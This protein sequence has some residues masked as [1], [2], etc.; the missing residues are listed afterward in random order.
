MLNASIRVVLRLRLPMNNGNADSFPEGRLHRQIL[1]SC[2][3][4]MFS[5]WLD[6]ISMPAMLPVF[7]TLWPEA[8]PPELAW[9]L[10]TDSIAFAVWLVPM[11]W[12]SDRLGSLQLLSGGLV[13]YGRASVICA[14]TTS[15]EVTTAARM[16]QLA[17]ACRSGM[18]AD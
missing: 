14:F 13:L 12:V 11:G 2:A 5:V 7:R 6:S 17:A 9:V 15:I 4:A 10:N 18:A 8:S 1:A 3:V 16:A